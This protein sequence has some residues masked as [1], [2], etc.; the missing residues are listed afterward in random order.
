PGEAYYLPFRHRP[1]RPAQQELLPD[2]APPSAADA[3]A[4]IRNLPTIDSAEM[5]PLRALLED[6]TVRKTAQNSKFDTLVLRR[7]GVRLAGVDFDTMIA[8]YVLDPGRR[9]HGL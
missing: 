7:A 8:S 4:A 5:A 1:H 9:S 3:S 2:S 6:P